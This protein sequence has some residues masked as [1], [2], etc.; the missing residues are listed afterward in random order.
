VLRRG[1]AWISFQ[2]GALNVSSDLIGIAQLGLV[3][4][5]GR[6]GLPFCPVANFG[7]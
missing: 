5:S 4:L 7:L 2:V 6:G 3:N 1:Q